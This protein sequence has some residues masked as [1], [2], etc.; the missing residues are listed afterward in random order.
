MSNCRSCGARILWKTT[1]RGNKM[2]VNFDDDL[3]E[4]GSDEEFDANRMTAH[5]DTCPQ[6]DQHRGKSKQQDLGF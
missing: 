6:A 2:P 3:C 4:G 1:K 5:W